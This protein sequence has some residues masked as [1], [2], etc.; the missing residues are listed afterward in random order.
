MTWRE[1][2]TFIRHLPRDSALA[3]EQLGEEAEWDT[4]AHLLARIANSVTA[5]NY[6]RG[7][8]QMPKSLEIKPPGQDRTAEAR[9]VADDQPKGWGE[10]N[11]LFDGG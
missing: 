2:R 5:A 6:Q 4:G 1:L 8:K 10:L 3:R 11:D 7:G 9:R